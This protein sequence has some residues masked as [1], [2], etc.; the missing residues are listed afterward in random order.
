[1]IKKQNK[2]VVLINAALT[3]DEEA[4]AE[5]VELIHACEME[6]I[7]IWT[8]HIKAIT[9][10]TY[11]G[12]GKT[13]EFAQELS[14]MEVDEVIVQ[15]TLTPLQA[16]NLETIFDLPVIDRSE[17]I[18]EIFEQRAHTQEAKL[19]VRS[20]KLKKQRSRLIGTSAS[21]G[22]QSGGRNKG[23]GEKQLE[24]DRRMLKQQIAECEKQ[25]KE[26]SKHRTLQH[27]Q[28][29]KQAF[30]HVAL[31]GYTN[32]GKSTLLNAMLKQEERPTHAQVFVKDQLFATL[33]TSLRRIQLPHAP[34]MICADTVGFVSDLPHELIHA[35]HATL[36][37]IRNADLLLH[38]V[39]ASS[40]LH[41][42]QMEI[43]EQTLKEL[44]ADHI[45]RIVVYNKCDL[46]AIPF[47][48]VHHRALTLSARLEIG[49][50]ELLE[51]IASELYG[52]FVKISI[53]IP[54]THP[55]FTRI[56]YEMIIESQENRSE[57]AYFTGYI[58]KNMLTKYVNYVKF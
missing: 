17:L 21:L 30:Y 48:E 23:K 19:Q 46:A 16:A 29:T 43:T 44:N 42:Q 49:I 45:P 7:A 11:L 9:T 3:E 52:S 4:I 25:L 22:R 37:E 36:D 18:V 39:D 10:A 8:Q 57:T 24:L 50:K 54:Y 14:T 12:S 35:F 20:A 55:D 33:D 41:Y 34:M 31:I 40:S 27:K 56:L 26:L 58:R 2:R 53:E 13:K 5:T 28:R 15:Q 38:V 51:E 32:A 6:L 1:M 47:P